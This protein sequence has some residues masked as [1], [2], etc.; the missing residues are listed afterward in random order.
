[1]VVAFIPLEYTID[2]PGR[3]P[4]RVS[5]GAEELTPTFPSFRNSGDWLAAGTKRL[6]DFA[7]RGLISLLFGRNGSTSLVDRACGI[8]VRWTPRIA[9]PGAALSA[10]PLFGAYGCM[11]RA[12]QN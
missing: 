12:V 6:M 3:V 5:S 2:T 9:Y 4:L 8:Y 7:R 1:M 11:R 10:E